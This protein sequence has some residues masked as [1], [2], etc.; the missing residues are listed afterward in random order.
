MRN[1]GNPAAPGTPRR[2]PAHLHSR[3]A[4]AVR[5][6]LEDDSAPGEPVCAT[7]AAIAGRR[8]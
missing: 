2:R 1:S 7:A 4:A 5:G 3:D 8:K 6:R